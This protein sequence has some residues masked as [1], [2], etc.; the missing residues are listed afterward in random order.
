MSSDV[1]L[2]CYAYV[3]VK[4]L[5]ILPNTHP[6]RCTGARLW[7]NVAVKASVDHDSLYSLVLFY[8]ATGVD[9]WPVRKR[10]G[11]VLFAEKSGRD[12]GEKRVFFYGDQTDADSWSKAWAAQALP[13]GVKHGPR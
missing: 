6:G 5:P 1:P 2:A 11:H 7:F 4:A 13:A 12:G 3:Y 10:R 8:M 9:V